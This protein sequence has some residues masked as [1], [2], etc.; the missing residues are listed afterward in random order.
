MLLYLLI[1]D[2]VEDENEGSLQRIED[3]EDVRHGNGFLI[4]EQN[5]KAPSQ[6]QQHN[7]HQRPLDPSS[8]KREITHI[9]HTRGSNSKVTI[10]NAIKLASVYNL[11][12]Q[13]WNE[14]EVSG[15]YL[16]QTIITIEIIINDIYFKK[17]CSVLWIDVNIYKQY[18]KN[19]MS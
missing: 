4:E 3:R 15:K 1:H 19:A 16:T 11:D 2:A 13:C 14:M 8:V 9:F 12:H 6:S 5:T 18:D 7:Q 10:V 17:Q